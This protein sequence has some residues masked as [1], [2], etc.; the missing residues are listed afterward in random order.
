MKKCTNSFCSQQIGIE[1]KSK[2]HPCFS[3][4]GHLKYARMHLPVAPKCNIQCNYCNRKYDCLNESRPGVTS[5]ILTP[6]EAFQKFLIVKEKVENLSVI[7]FAGPGD[8]LA[9][10]DKIKETVE[11]I[12]QN[13]PDITFCL[14]TNGLMLPDYAQ[15]IIDIGISHVTITINTVNPEIGKLIYSG[16]DPEILLKNQLKGLEYLSNRGIIC[17]VNIVAIK[18]IN[19]FHIEE[20]VKTVKKLGA[21]K[22]NI[23]QLIPAKGTKFENMSLVS[24]KEL[25]EIRHKCSAHLSQMYHCQQC[26]ADAI[27]LLHK[28]RSI[29]F[30]NIG[31]T[32]K[33]ESS[34]KDKEY[35]LAVASES[36]EIIDQHFGQAKDFL[37][38]KVSDNVIKLIDKRSVDKY[39]AGKEECD[40]KKDKIDNIIEILKD[41]NAVLS[42]RIGNNPKE[43]LE[44]NNI[45]SFEI[46][47]TVENAIKTVVNK[48]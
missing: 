12:N 7:G 3:E 10:F 13:D 48:F 40:D 42:L 28:D 46:Y 33:T 23:M 36:G 41:C 15:E 24:N 43:K 8:A 39:C 34:T 37:I 1:E 38:Y 11:L 26:R 17:K 9:N 16:V 44:N 18:G 21:F 30:R 25:N 31:V 4:S 45:K 32:D 35:I 19:D 5:E 6:E 20:V 14:S 22:T 47:D 2:K 27:G 29:E